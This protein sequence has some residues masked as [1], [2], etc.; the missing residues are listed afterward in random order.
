MDSDKMNPEEQLKFLA[1]AF[2]SFSKLYVDCP[3]CG[4]T[5]QLASCTLHW[6]KKADDKVVK[7]LQKISKEQEKLEEEQTKID[8]QWLDLKERQTE[9]QY[10][11]KIMVSD[12]TKLK[13]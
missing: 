9:L 10:E 11:A 7:S 3:C 12:F 1:Q 4:Y 8:E 2:S 5:I 6:G 13:I